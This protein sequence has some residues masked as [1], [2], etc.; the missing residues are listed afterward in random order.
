MVFFVSEVR[1]SDGFRWKAERKHL[2]RASLS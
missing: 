2:V 1:Y